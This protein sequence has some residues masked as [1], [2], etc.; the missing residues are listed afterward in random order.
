LAV[1]AAEAWPEL[2]VL[3]VYVVCPLENVPPAPL[4]GAVKVTCTPEIALPLTTAING[5][6]N[7]VPICALCG[8]PLDTAMVV[9]EGEFTVKVKLP[10][11]ASSVAVMLDCPPATPVA[12]PALLIVA[13]FCDPDAHVTWPVRLAVEPSLYVPV[14]VN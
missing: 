13:T 11:T 14:A 3:V 10:A 6:A 2:S 8:E 4:A 1:K 5:L 7:A 12:S 9:C